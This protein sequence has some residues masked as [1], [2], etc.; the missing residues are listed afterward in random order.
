MK[1]GGWIKLYRSIESKYWYSKDHVYKV[2]CHLL[3][4]ANH[5]KNT[6]GEYVVHRGSLIAS[7]ASISKVTGVSEKSVRTALNILTKDKVIKTKSLG[8]FGTRI[9]VINYEDYQGKGKKEKSDKPTKPPKETKEEPR[10]KGL[11]R[12]GWPETQGELSD[13]NWAKLCKWREEGTVPPVPKL[14]GGR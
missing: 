8:S 6:K 11:W 1:N 4:N 9:D 5:E 10:K 3:M 2:F 13:A 12:D 7:R 14:R